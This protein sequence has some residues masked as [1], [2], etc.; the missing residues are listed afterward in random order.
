MPTQIDNQQNISSILHSH[1]I[2][3][4]AEQ[5][6]LQLQTPRNDS[7]HHV[8]NSSFIVSQPAAD[9]PPG[10]G[11]DIFE[12]TTL[13]AQPAAQIYNVSFDVELKRLPY[14]A[15]QDRTFE[16]HKYYLLNEILAQNVHGFSIKTFKNGRE[17]AY[18]KQKPCI[19]EVTHP[20]KCF[21]C[22]K[23][24]CHGA[25]QIGDCNIAYEQWR[26]NPSEENY[27]NVY[28]GFGGTKI[29]HERHINP[30]HPETRK[31]IEN[32]IIDKINGNPQDKNV[33]KVIMQ[34]INKNVDNQY[35]VTKKMTRKP[36]QGQ[37]INNIK[38]PINKKIKPTE[39]CINKYK[40]H[41]YGGFMT[42]K[43]RNTDK[44][45]D[46][47]CPNH[48]DKPSEWKCDL[49]DR[50]N[51]KN[52]Y[53]KVTNWSKPSYYKMNQM[54]CK[55]P[56][57]TVRFY[58]NH[59]DFEIAGNDYVDPESF[60][61]DKTKM[62]SYGFM[63]T[64]NTHHVNVDSCDK[65]WYKNLLECWIHTYVEETGERRT[66]EIEEMVKK[67]LGSKNSIIE[68]L[69]AHQ[70]VIYPFYNKCLQILLYRNTPTTFGFDLTFNDSKDIGDQHLK[71]VQTTLTIL[72]NLNHELSQHLVNGK[73]EG[74]EQIG[75]HL[76]ECR[77]LQLLFG[78]P[79]ILNNIPTKWFSDKHLNN[80]NLP[81]WIDKEV[82]QWI[83]TNKNTGHPLYVALTKKLEN[84]NNP[85][86]VGAL[87]KTD[88]EC[89]MHLY[90]R[91]YAKLQDDK[92]S[93]N[94]HK[95]F[96]VFTGESNRIHVGIQKGDLGIIVSSL[97]TAEQYY[98][99]YQHELRANAE[100]IIYV[101]QQLLQNDGINDIN[102]R[103]LELR[104]IKISQ[105]YKATYPLAQRIASECETFGH[106]QIAGLFLYYNKFDETWIKNIKEFTDQTGNKIRFFTHSIAST[107][108]DIIFHHYGCYKTDYFYKP[109]LQPLTDWVT[110]NIRIW[111]HT[112]QNKIRDDDPNNKPI[113]HY[114]NISEHIDQQMLNPDNV[115]ACIAGRND[116][117]KFGNVGNEQKHSIMGR[118]SK[119]MSKRKNL[120]TWQRNK[121]VGLFHRNIKTIE[122]NKKSKYNPYSKT[123]IKEA[124]QI[125]DACINAEFYDEFKKNGKVFD[126][127]NVFNEVDKSCNE[128]ITKRE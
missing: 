30:K 31:F 47:R 118:K 63:T 19:Y 65:T 2:G 28:T 40:K 126:L 127:S 9:V 107:V 66:P 70:F 33:I 99:K 77:L 88:T 81:E 128:M 80:K 59:A 39:E 11:E 121:H 48:K 115:E 54:D 51:K 44:T 3:H 27:K 20:G 101:W 26:L 91:V 17:T 120:R 69:Q 23:N 93:K 73:G 49:Q 82:E 106:K 68:S 108:A 85:I 124:K 100:D 97:L 50:K 4:I 58:I 34:G 10:I 43:T 38:Q 116:D 103:D 56:G 76:V 109:M 102:Q 114:V 6:P 60:I 25:C 87:K 12:G 15:Q 37:T 45:Y 53:G 90:R 42:L 75:V 62:I 119:S 84:I 55:K 94:N 13:F 35:K 117:G 32:F 64:A 110:L 96:H 52:K 112:F 125:E 104:S 98:Y 5:Q 16:I 123:F 1:S 71:G 46:S 14:I 113:L 29:Q 21:K 18:S 122:K 41:F 86:T 72:D 61:K 8:I 24:I 67:Q 78:D 111:K 57:G 92:V 74:R 7:N 79:S 22:A 89:L 36:I 83:T 105:K 95:D